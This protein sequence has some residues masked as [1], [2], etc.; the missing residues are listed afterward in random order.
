MKKHLI[1]FYRFNRLNTNI[2][3]QD[4]LLILQFG[5]ETIFF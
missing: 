1:F 3:N 5:L 2:L 4:K